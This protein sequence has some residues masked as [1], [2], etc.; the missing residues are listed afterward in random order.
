MRSPD[1][2]GHAFVPEDTLGQ[3]QLLHAC[4]GEWE[5]LLPFRVPHKLYRRLPTHTDVIGR[6]AAHLNAR[7]T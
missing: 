4:Y 5:K 6:G 7:G 1:K 2:K 3:S